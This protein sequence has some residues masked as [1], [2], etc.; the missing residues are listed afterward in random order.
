[1]RRLPL[2]PWMQAALVF[3]SSLSAFGSAPDAVNDSYSATNTTVLS[4]PASGVLAND[5]DADSQTLSITPITSQT[6][7]FDGVTFD[8][9]FTPNVY[10]SLEP[11]TY[12]SAIVTAV[13]TTTTSQVAGFPNSTTGFMGS[14][15]VG[16]LFGG[17]TA[18]IGTRAVNLPDGNLGT[19]A[20][21]GFE[22]S[23]TSGVMITNEAGADIVVF[24]SASGE[25][26][27]FDEAYMMQVHDADANTWSSWI[28]IQA[29]AGTTVYGSGNARL[30]H[31]SYELSDFGIPANGRVDRVRIVNMTDEDRMVDSSGQGVVIP[32]DTGNT[33]SF[34]PDPIGALT[35]FASGAYDPDI[36]YVGSLHALGATIPAYEATTALGATVSLQADGSFTYDSSSSSTLSALDIG[37]NAA[38]SF[39]YI[40][41]DGHQGY[42]RAVVSITVNGPPPPTLT[43]TLSGSDAI[44]TWPS[45]YQNF[46]LQS[47]DSISSPNWVDV[48]F[49]PTLDGDNYTL[50]LDASSGMSFFRLTKPD[51]P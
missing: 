33:S 22:L 7:T 48:D 12:G 34:L 18:T 46:L 13:P 26:E 3:A 14:L 21:S 35:Q 11:G 30:N 24:E 37:Q 9:A 27:G 32:E 15:S 51:V 17:E 38:D 19:I 41:T 5:S 36:V 29:V 20:R 39:Y 44:F 50:T 42:S 31:T 43:I 4:V 16:M 1:M 45:T 10:K 49:E 40:I 47:T 25:G 28:Y 6:F 8:Q 2:L 23:W